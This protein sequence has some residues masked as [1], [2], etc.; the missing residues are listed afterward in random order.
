MSDREPNTIR[1]LL[2]ALLEARERRDREERFSERWHAVDREMHAVERA[3]FQ[4]PPD[5]AAAH[6]LGHDRS[7]ERAG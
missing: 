2:D 7:L 6:R 5:G 3:I 1:N 4:L